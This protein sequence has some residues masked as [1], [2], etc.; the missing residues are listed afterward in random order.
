MSIFHCVCADTC[1]I[2]VNNCYEQNLIKIYINIPSF[3]QNMA[4]TYI[5]FY[6]DDAS[7]TI[8]DEAKHVN[9]FKTKGSELAIFDIDFTPDGVPQIFGPLPSISSTIPN[10]IFIQPFYIQDFI[11]PTEF[12]TKVTSVMEDFKDTNSQFVF[13]LL[14]KMEPSHSFFKEQFQPLEYK[15]VDLVEAEIFHSIPSAALCVEAKLLSDQTLWF[16]FSPQEQGRR[17]RI[18]HNSLSHNDH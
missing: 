4:Q 11:D 8:I 5:R 3:L 1:W 14:P 18:L 12:E 7:R 10:F 17:A 2:K 16:D 15:M 13:P 9:F 6:M